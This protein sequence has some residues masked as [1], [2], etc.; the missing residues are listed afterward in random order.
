MRASCTVEDAAA[1]AAEVRALV[2]AAAS[3]AAEVREIVESV[4][5]GGDA[6][7]LEWERRFGGERGGGAS[8]SGAAP[9]P[10][11]PAGCR[12]GRRVLRLRRVPAF[13]RWPLP[14][15]SGRAPRGPGLAGAGGS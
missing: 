4:R 11:A 5:E 9:P 12:P 3:V 8:A 1:V 13:P 2:P 14:R 10:A 6:A 15:P 7:V